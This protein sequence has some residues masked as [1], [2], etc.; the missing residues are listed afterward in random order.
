MIKKIKFHDFRMFQGEHTIDLK[1]ITIFIGPNNSGKSTLIRLIENLIKMPSNESRNSSKYF[2]DPY[3]GISKTY[4]NI[5]TYLT[6]FQE[7]MPEEFGNYHA[8][9]FIIDNLNIKGDSALGA[10]SS[11]QFCYKECVIAT[12]DNM[13][14]N[15]EIGVNKL[16]L[17]KA[18]PHAKSE[19]YYE[20][21]IHFDNIYSSQA[22]LFKEDDKETEEFKSNLKFIIDC[23]WSKNLIE[24]Y[25]SLHGKQLP[26]FEASNKNKNDLNLIIYTEQNRYLLRDSYYSCFSSYLNDTLLLIQTNQR[27]P[28]KYKQALSF[29]LKFVFEKYILLPLQQLKEIQEN[30]MSFSAYR[31]M[32]FDDKDS[33]ASLAFKELIKKFSFYLTTKHKRKKGVYSFG[34]V[35]YEDEI[36]LLKKWLKNFEIGEGLTMDYKQFEIFKVIIE[37]GLERYPVE[38]GFGNQQLLPLIL[39]MFSN[40]CGIFFI[41]EPESHLHPYMQS[42]LGDFFTDMLNYKIG[43]MKGEKPQLIIETHSEYLI[44]RLQYLVANRSI[45]SEDVAIYYIN[46]ADRIPAEARQIQKMEILKDGSLGNDFGPGFFDEAINLKLELLKL[47]NPKKK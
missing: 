18:D 42:K 20:F 5:G 43:W 1:P 44:R 28:Q 41:E 14:W 8:R 16:G 25:Y 37:K 45:G 7:S 36:S 26:I 6:K 24:T 35:F 40:P 23:G 19:N 22:K 29:V 2:V 27:I 32:F 34:E 10:P 33:Q 4:E 13:S 3:S 30:I 15:S 11:F 9:E 47:K 17:E 38:L 12:F 39:G 46:K 31:G 21:N